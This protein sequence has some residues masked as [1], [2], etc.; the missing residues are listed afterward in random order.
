MDVD[1]GSLSGLVTVSQTSVG[2]SLGSLHQ[3]HRSK[4]LVRTLRRVLSSR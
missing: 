4:D 2:M 1:G 3:A